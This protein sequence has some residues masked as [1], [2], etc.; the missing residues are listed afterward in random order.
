V[1]RI[2]TTTKKPVSRARRS[3]G[4]RR[5]STPEADELLA[6]CVLV[7]GESAEGFRDVVEQ[8]RARFGEVNEFESA[9]VED[10]ALLWW[11]MRR[12]HAVETEWLEQELEKEEPGDERRRIGNGFA[13]LVESGKLMRL[14]RYEA[15][16]RRTYRGLMRELAEVRVR[17][18]VELVPR[19][20]ET[21]VAVR[22]STA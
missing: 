20:D 12:A 8:H 10:A 21:R 6:Q 13:R 16:L 18:W 2:E 17:R 9:M 14:Q 7:E 4:R 19:A 15:S 5:A 3:R 11:R 22:E 1:N